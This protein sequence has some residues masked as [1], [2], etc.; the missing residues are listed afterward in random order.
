LSIYLE[1]VTTGGCMKN[2]S[3]LV[4]LIKGAGELASGVACRLFRS[5]FRIC[6][7]DIEQPQAV[8]RTVSFCEAVYD[9]EKEIEGV[10]ARRI[11]S[12]EEVPLVWQA[13][14]IALLVDPEAEIKNSLKPD[15]LVDAILAKKNLGT[16]IKDALLVIGLGPGFTA[17]K[18]VH[19]VIETNRG[20]N[21]GR[22]FK[23]G[24]AEPN[25]GIPGE[26][27]GFSADRVFRAPKAG[28]FLN[29]KKIGD[30]VQIGD[31]VAKVN[32]ELVKASFSGVV[33]GLLRDGTK[34]YP[35]MKAGD[36]DPRG[37]CPD[38]C[39]LRPGHICQD[40]EH[41]P[42]FTGRAV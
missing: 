24:E 29:V 21:L 39:S 33:R 8:R 31:V 20:H 32:S 9:G 6:L 30:F 36:I 14:K 27:A 40:L 12:P 7:T 11:S 38:H 18:D 23:A 28:K 2:L 41:S 26:I 25:T 3:D 19:V 22:I 4:I 17:A 37:N 1:L 5:H 16:G 35:G 34:V 42:Y 15:V 13:G 10:I